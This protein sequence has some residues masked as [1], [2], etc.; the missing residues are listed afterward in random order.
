MGSLRSTP[1]GV[2]TSIVVVALMLGG[3]L[4]LTSPASAA[5]GD[6]YAPAYTDGDWWNYTVSGPYGV[7]TVAG[8][9]E[10]EFAQAQGWMRF[11]VD[12][13]TSY[14]GE[15]AWVMKVTGKL[16]LTGSWTSASESGDT[17]M[18]SKVSGREWRAVDDLA[19]LG[20]SLSY[21]GD[22]EIATMA[23]PEF[24]TM[25]IGE[26]RTLDAP[27]RMMLF[28]VPIAQLP[29]EEHSVGITTVFTTGSEV[30]TVEEEWSY[31]ASYMGLSTVQGGTL[32]YSN[33]NRFHVKGNVTTDGKPTPFEGSMYYEGQPRKG[34]TVDRLRHMEL[35]NYYVSQVVNQPDLVVGE[36]EFNS[37]NDFPV[38]GTEINITS[39]IHNLGARDVMDVLVELWAAPE[40]EPPSRQNSTRIEL[41]EGNHKALVHF[42]WSAEVVGNWV[43]YLRV[44]PVNSIVEAREDNNEVSMLI[45]VS[46]FA[47]KPNL[48][49][50]DNAILLDPPS[51]VHNRTAVK[52]TVAVSNLGDGSAYNVTLDFYLGRPGA[53]G[54]PIAWRETIDAIHK[55]QKRVASIWWTPDIA[56]SHEIWVYIDQNN[57]VNETVESDNM[58][59]V[60]ILVIASPEGGVDLVVAKI[61][62]LDTDGLEKSPYPRGMRVT[63]QAIVQNLGKEIAPRV[64]LSIYV[65]EETPTS[66][67]GSH[68]GS[69]DIGD[70]VN[71]EVKWTIDV[72]DGSHEILASVVALGSVEAHPK[73]N[74]R[75]QVIEVGNRV[76]PE[77]ELLSINIT[78]S[79]DVLEPL[80]T[81]L[82]SGK[83]RIAKNGFE[84]PGATVTVRFKDQATPVVVTTN[85]VG[86][87]L[88]ELTAPATPGSHRIIVTA[89]G[90]NSE[91]EATYTITVKAASGGDTDSSGEDEGIDS[92]YFIVSVVIILAIGMPMTYYLLLSKS[93]INRRI[94]R[95]HEE[96]VEIVDEEK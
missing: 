53:G 9:Y 81:V 10:V 96:I 49:L 56:G 58:D 62:V 63:V 24:F 91:G 60:T 65:D 50:E 15:V 20:S 37:T 57:T 52:V 61:K 70:M 92:L 27:L 85:E 69:I 89:E 75:T 38:E 25:R 83:V 67:L 76:L 33:Q 44:D 22:L 28:P 5:S 79:T 80:Q 29:Q 84:V 36:D 6:L 17:T 8:D 35:L 51:P 82:V 13:T 66:L 93:A 78:P 39:T 21:T 46:P 71:W 18:D 90:T 43:F 26:N 30:V 16:H 74:S 41:I 72:E 95:V 64:H 34:V 1:A 11:E 23:G 2:V 73:D 86:R 12:G 94:R 77:P 45:V 87:F 31:L 55:G 19:L 47:P 14:L 54:V 68:E 42:N 59:S 88:V 32:T 48:L 3:A 40:D 4:V 7:P